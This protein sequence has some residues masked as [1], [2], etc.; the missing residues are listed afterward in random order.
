MTTA[1]VRDVNRQLLDFWGTLGI[2][3]GWR[4][5]AFEKF[6]ERLSS[7]YLLSS[8]LPNGCSL[9][10]DLR[11]HVQRQIYFQGV[12]EPIE[13]YLFSCLVKP[14][15]TVVDAGTNIGQ[16]TLLA[17]TLVGITGSVHGFEPVPDTF[18]RVS[19]NVTHNQ[20]SNVHLNQAG[21][22]QKA[23]PLRLSLSEDMEN[24][25]GAYSAGATNASKVVESVAISFD[26]YVKEHQ[27]SRVD[28]V[29]MD[30][31]GAEHSALLGMRTVISRD[32][33]ILLMEVNRSALI[34][35][36]SSPEEILE[37][38]GKEFGYD[39]YLILENHCE[40]ISDFSNVT[41]SNF[42]FVHPSNRSDLVH[43]SWDFKT[44][45]RWSR[46]GKK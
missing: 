39:A 31:E 3:P 20:L 43:Q 17:S 23:M 27:I 18:R 12:Y 41:Q 36:N 45:L 19:Q 10:C 42:I 16:Y 22:W 11:D 5:S 6:G 32:H 37:L 33:P 26:S 28:L 29:K 1:L 46:S 40:K 25:S 24:N 34:K 38:M 30:I 4:Y 13:A 35:M 7:G 14:G 44:I 8:E 21:L 15:M 9:P 2:A